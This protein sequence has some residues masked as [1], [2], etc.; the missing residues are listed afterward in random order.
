ME[1]THSEN[2]GTDPE[3]SVDE[4]TGNLISGESKSV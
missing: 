3:W 2:T 1:S 4:S